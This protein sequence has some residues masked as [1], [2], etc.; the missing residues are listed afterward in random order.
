MKVV[1]ENL[2]KIFQS[3]HEKGKEVVAVNNFTFTIPD[4]KLVGLLGPS[5]CGKSTTLYMICGLQKPSGGKIFFGDDDVTALAPE[6]RGVGL[7]FQNYAL[8][9]H[10]TVKQNILFPLQNLKGEDKLSKED[11]LKR[12]YDAAKLVQID[13][14]MD[15]KPSELSGGQQ[16]RVAIARALVKMP[17]V[18]LLD[19]P[20]SNLDARLRLQTREEIR[21]IQRETNITT[22]FVTHDQEEAMSISDMIVVMKLGVVQQIGKPQDVY[23]S[24]ANL[25]VAKFL[26]TPPINVFEGEVKDGKVYI[27][28]D[29]VLDVPGIEDEDVYVG[30]RPEGFILNE[31][32]ALGCKLKSVE[33]MGRDVSIVSENE[34]ALSPIIRSIIDATTVVD[35]DKEEVRFDVKPNKIFIFSR[36]R[37]DWTMANEPATVYDW[38]KMRQTLSVESEGKTID[39]GT[40]KTPEIAQK[41]ATTAEKKA[42]Q[43]KFW[44]SFVKSLQNK[45]DKL[46]KLC[47]PK[48]KPVELAFDTPYL[49]VTGCDDKG[50]PIYFAGVEGG[51]LVTTSD[52]NEALNV[53]AEQSEN[54]IV[55]Y[56]MIGDEKFYP[57]FTVNNA[58]KDEQRIFLSDEEKEKCFEYMQQDNVVETEPTVQDG[59]V[60][61]ESVEDTIAEIAES[62]EEAVT[63][64]VVEEEVKEEL[65]QNDSEVK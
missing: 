31:K 37:I 45:F 22:V 25:F 50:A 54:G 58:A 46:I 6:N 8:Y 39:F 49:C 55:A 29:A 14:L 42:K 7:V 26:G 19:E 11:M 35:K 27:G 40:L 5:G 53:F 17:R 64:K 36:K 48:A 2:T 43:P 56:V 20:L 41:E 34:H 21:R 62:S 33:V 57:S 28:D 3:R 18:L 61:S 24:P 30:I 12:A 60:N 9:P 1:L 15:R 16:Q 47:T 10:M 63:E 59:E 13:E 4:G 32:G 52:I 44:K 38:S 65:N 23:D 51:K